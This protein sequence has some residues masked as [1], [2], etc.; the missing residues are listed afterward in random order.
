MD[1]IHIIPRAWE[2]RTR[3][4]NSGALLSCR[5]L[6]TYSAQVFCSVSDAES[7]KKTLTGVAGGEAATQGAVSSEHWHCCG[8]GRQQ[9]C[10]EQLRL[11]I[12]KT[13]KLVY[14]LF[15][16]TWGKNPATTPLLLQ[17]KP[18]PPSIKQGGS[19]GLHRRAGTWF[20]R[21]R[22]GVRGAVRWGLFLF[23]EKTEVSSGP[24]GVP[25]IRNHPECCP[26][27]RRP[28]TTL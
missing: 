5:T 19:D 21:T 14:K 1:Y 10:K 8:E 15:P 26:T 27:P 28:S 11:K 24:I 3:D 25:C 9:A 18:F 20:Q 22:S 2:L 7:A 16:N 4:P 23:R 13:T 12:Q 6:Q 17:L